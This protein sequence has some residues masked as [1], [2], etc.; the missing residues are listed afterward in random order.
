MEKLKFMSFLCG[1]I[2]SLST[3]KAMI[4]LSD[5]TLENNQ[6]STVARPLTPNH[7]RGELLYEIYGVNSQETITAFQLAIMNFHKRSFASAFNLV[8]QNGSNINNPF[9]ITNNG[10]LVLIRQEDKDAFMIRLAQSQ[11]PN[12]QW[13]ARYIERQF[14]TW[15]GGP[16]VPFVLCIGR[17]AGREPSVTLRL[18]DTLLREGTSDVYI[19]NL[20]RDT[21]QE[22]QYGNILD[23]LVTVIGRPAESLATAQEPILAA[24]DRNPVENTT[25]LFP[26]ELTAY[27]LKTVG[28]LGEEINSSN[29]IPAELSSGAGEYDLLRG[30]ADEDKLILSRVEV[31]DLGGCCGMLFS[32]LM[33]F[34]RRRR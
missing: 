19:R 21:R 25:R 24:A 15:N 12:A 30:K 29:V 1:A 33:N 3:V 8:E 16:V 2:F 22:L 13:E 14:N 34:I 6:R 4:P 10:I 18:L 9:S 32:T 7:G 26:S 11:N 28:V 27:F 20:D 31:A 5:L 17:G 23:A